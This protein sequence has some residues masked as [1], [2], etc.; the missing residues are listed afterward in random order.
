MTSQIPAKYA[1]NVEAKKAVNSALANLEFEANEAGMSIDVNG[2]IGILL[3]FLIGLIGKKPPKPVPA[4]EPVDVEPIPTKPTPFPEPK[5]STGPQHRID[6]GE[7]KVTGIQEGI[8]AKWDADGNILSGSV[9]QW[10]E[11]PADRVDAIC[12]G[13]DNAPHVFRLMTDCTPEAAGYKFKPNDSSWEDD[14]QPGSVE[15]PGAEPMRLIWEDNTDQIYLT[16]EYQDFGCRNWIRGSVTPGTG[17]DI[18]MPVYVGPK[19]PDTG[20][21][22]KIP[23][24]R[25]GRKI[26]VIHVGRH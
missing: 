25:K 19:Y 21:F 14:P 17:Q 4:P 5:P 12:A 1:D 3:P 18:H 6:G 10:A 16:H 23:L 24:N 8:G 15:D 7:A 2:L 26:D 9:R 20:K 13:Q 22:A 11:L